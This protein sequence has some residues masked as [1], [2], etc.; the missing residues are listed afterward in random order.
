MPVQVTPSSLS[1]YQ[2]ETVSIFV[3]A[4]L[5]PCS[6]A[7]KLRINW[8]E[9][10]HTHKSVSSDP[11]YWKIPA[12]LLKVD[13]TY[14]LTVNVSDDSGMFNMGKATVRVMRS[15]LV[16]QITGG[17]RTV[18]K[19]SFLTLDAVNSYDPDNR[20]NPLNYTWSCIQGGSNYGS[21]CNLPANLAYTGVS[22]PAGGLVAK[23]SY[24]FTVRVW[25][26]DGRTG[27]ATVTIMVVS[28]RPPQVTIEGL[29]TSRSTTL[30]GDTKVNPSVKFSLQGYVDFA[31]STLASSTNISLAWSVISGS[32][33]GGA[34]LRSVALSSP[35]VYFN[36]LSYQ[37]TSTIY[38]FPLVLGIGAMTPGSDYRLRLQAMDTRN[39]DT[40]A[41]SEIS[42]VVN[43]VPT[44]GSFDASPRRGFVLVTRFTLTASDWVDDS[45]DYPLTYSFFYRQLDSSNNIAL[46]LN[47]YLALASGVYLPKVR[48]ARPRH[49]DAAQTH[50]VYLTRCLYVLL[51]RPRTQRAI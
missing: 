51:H 15:P 31:N 40:Q 21:S 4:S 48:A 20:A 2:S 36:A 7:T 14:N 17:D 16:V 12:Y 9:S 1:V 46:A 49:R 34:A 10:S 50:E 24:I 19:G 18:P 37:T 43:S 29:S 45:T 32:F 44:S 6:M 35:T 42:L 30:A 13:T 41:Y 5:S 25:V 39:N 47:S 8:T 23:R 11:R 3:A 38:P 28:G 27:S 22:L 26:A 33:V